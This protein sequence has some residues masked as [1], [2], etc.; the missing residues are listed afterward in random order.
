MKEEYPGHP[1]SAYRKVLGYLMAKTHSRLDEWMDLTRITEVILQNNTEY[2]FGALVE[3]IDEKIADEL[4]VR[5]APPGGIG[6][7]PPPPEMIEVQEL[8]Q[9]QR[10]DWLQIGI[11]PFQI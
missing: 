1:D 9:G 5:P 7:P 3:D 8:V 10:E 11:D 6:L 4:P 2:E